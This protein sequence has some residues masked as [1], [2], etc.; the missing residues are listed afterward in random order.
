MFQGH[1]P[2]DARIER[3]VSRLQKITWPLTLFIDNVNY[4]SDPALEKL[5][6]QLVFETPT[7]VSLMISS[8][9]AL[10]I[11]AVRCK[12]E[13]LLKEHGTADL[14]FDADGVREVFGPELCDR[15]A[16]ATIHT[17]V[18]NTEGWPSAV[19]LMQ[20]LLADARDPERLLAEF[21]GADQ[22]IA[23]LLNLQVFARFDGDLQCFLLALSL[24]RDFDADLARE[25]TGDVCAFEHLQYLWRHN[26]FM[27]PV[28][29]ERRYRLHN[30]FKEFLLDRAQHRLT[31]ERRRGILE[32]AAMR[33]AGEEQYADAIDYAF[34]AESLTL[35]A[36][37]LERT[38]PVF[39]RDLGH[40]H[41]Y[42]GWVEQLHAAGVEGG[43]ETDYWYVW[44]LVFHR[45]YE[46]A[47]QEIARLTVRLRQST[48]SDGVDTVR[49]TAYGRRVDVIRIAIDVYTDHLAEARRDAQRWL[50][51]IE[52][53]RTDVVDS[54]FDVAT[55]ACG[56]AIHD[57][58]RSDLAEAR[59]MVR[60]ASA[61]IAQS[62]SA[63]GQGW[64]AVVDALIPLREGDYA[65]AYR[66]LTD[67]LQKAARALGE[68][69]GICGTMALAAAKAA[70]EMDQREAG[71]ALLLQGLRHI[72]T[73]GILD[74]AAYGLDAAVKLWPGHDTANFSL[75]TLRKTAAAYPPRL[76]MML[77]CYIVRRLLLL[78][79]TDE[80]LQ[81]AA[82]LGIDADSE[83]VVCDQAMAEHG[84]ALR[85]LVEATRTDLI[86]SARNFKQASACIVEETAR[87]RAE[88]RVSRLVELALNEAFLS[89]CTHDPMP[90]ARYLTRAISLASRYRYLR[91]FR[92]RGDLIA[93]LV[94]HTRMKDWPFINDDERRFFAEICSGVKVSGNP[95]L[96]QMQ[97][98]DNA[99]SLSETPTI[100]ELELLSLIEAGLSNQE[101]ADRLSLSRATVKWHLYNLYA[102]LGVK[103]RAAA[104]ARARSLNLFAR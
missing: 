2:D 69:V 90:A 101:I 70:V 89:Q 86:I 65:T 78:G 53:N 60:I 98:L 55:V 34:A 7:A 96:E 52:Q 74:T 46:Q 63:Y 77:S 44:A 71:E 13:G 91:P 17:V 40:L 32:R 24:L 61:S 73:H 16:P 39:V 83:Y 6:E 47:R 41:R 59:R 56:A 104:L 22:D 19:R 51:V 68:H 79:R 28:D 30:L 84:A 62:Q 64:V 99:G 1:E 50:D 26:V 38:A 95:L 21:S 93:G 9:E 92:D 88:R 31:S 15:L 43:W 66:N 82:A 100:R 29:G 85:D 18:R 3:I 67:A 14:S 4:C 8:T 81:E 5:F 75:T 48:Q 33:C 35:A 54:P 57:A 72:S 97:E 102:K 27:I 49:L 23:T 87:A 11:D 103:N 37:M 25:A 36:E 10:P 20:I 42:L 80:A 94:N 12:L 76:S 45:R 58:N